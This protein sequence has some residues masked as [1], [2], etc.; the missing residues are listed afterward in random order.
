M[1]PTPDLPKR[2]TDLWP[3]VVVG[4]SLWALAGV[5]LFVVTGMGPWTWTCVAGVVLG[6]IGFAIMAWQRAASRRG[7]RGAQRDL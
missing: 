5:V 4:T 7:A 2:W 6:F 3:P 1:K